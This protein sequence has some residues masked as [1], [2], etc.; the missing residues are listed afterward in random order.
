M[1]DD[2]LQKHFENEGGNDVALMN[3]W[4]YEVLGLQCLALRL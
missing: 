2:V 4:F 1:V 3:E